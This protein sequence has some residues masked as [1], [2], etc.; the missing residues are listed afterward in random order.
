MTLYN[1]GYTIPTAALSGGTTNLAGPNVTVANISGSAV[2]NVT[3]GTLQTL[4]VAGSD[5]TN[6]ITVSSGAQAGNTSLSVSGGLVTLN[7]TNPI[8]TATLSGGTINLNGPAVTA[9]NI[10]GNAVVNVTAGS[11][12]TLNVAGSNLANGVTVSSAASAGSTSLSVSGG[13]VTLNNTNLIPA[14][15]FSGGTSNL[16]GPNVTLANVSGGAGW[17]AS[18]RAA[19]RRLNATGGNTTVGSPATVTSASVTAGLVNLNNTNPMAFLGVSGG[20]INLNGGAAIGTADFNSRATPRSILRARWSSATS[21][22]STAG[23][24]PAFPAAIHSP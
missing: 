18:T 15:A 21:S 7:N 20:T 5:L 9:A 11:L 8:P 19:C 6:G 23:L 2:V 16:A 4:N 22:S 10:S 14:A 24:R 1:F 3:S 13:L 17:S 12:Q